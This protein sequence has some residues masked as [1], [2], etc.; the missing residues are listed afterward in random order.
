VEK[1]CP[2]KFVA[3][4]NFTG[5]VFIYGDLRD[6]CFLLRLVFDR[7]E[8]VHPQ[9]AVIDVLPVRQYKKGVKSWNR[10][11][12]TK[13]YVIECNIPDYNHNPLM[14]SRLIYPDFLLRKSMIQITAIESQVSCQI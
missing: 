13:T 6:N 7:P 8:D 10:R 1:L 5:Q 3:T 11:R 14:K 12:Y 4:E 2:G 9:I